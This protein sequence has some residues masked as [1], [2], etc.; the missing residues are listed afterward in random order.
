M[1]L[2]ESRLYKPASKFAVLHTYYYEFSREG[3]L[4][5]PCR[6]AFFSLALARRPQWAVRAENRLISQDFSIV[7]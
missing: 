3:L 1:Y 6:A 5:Q 2:S 7:C 4:D